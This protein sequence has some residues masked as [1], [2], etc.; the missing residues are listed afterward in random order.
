MADDLKI[1]GD[2][3][4]ELYESLLPQLF[5]L[6]SSEKDL[7]ANLANLTAGLK[8]VFDFFWVGFYIVKEDT[9][10]LG[11]FQGTVACTRISKGRGVCGA[12]WEQK[13]Y[14]LVPDVSQFDGHIACS[15]LS[16]SELVIPILKADEVIG[17]LDVDS[18]KL[19]DFDQTDVNY[20]S[21]VC[22]WVS[23]LM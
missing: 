1:T 13:K 6:I 5:N 10:V 23:D 11:P 14:I 17:V 19:N 22:R 3:K 15:S 12:A 4:S 18:S 20:L 16:K 2:T 7:T 8:E 9:L 21:K